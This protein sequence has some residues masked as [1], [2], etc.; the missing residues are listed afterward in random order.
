MIQ[1]GL[2]KHVHD[3]R[4]YDLFKTK[5]LGGVIPSFPK[6]LNLDDGQW[7]VDQ[8]VGFP[9]F[10]PFSPPQPYGCTNVTTCDLLR[11]EDGKLYNPQD[12]ENYTHANAKGGI[13]LRTAAEAGITLY[14]KDHPNY[15][16]VK[17][18]N[19]QGGYADWFDAVRLAI[20]VGFNEK[21]KVSI[22]TAW[23]SGFESVGSDGLISDF[24][25][26]T[27]ITGGHDW[28]G[29]GWVER[30]ETRL[31][32]KSWQ[33]QG[34]GDKGYSYFTRK[35]F[36][37]LMSEWSA[38]AFVY[39]KLTDGEQPIVISSTTKQWLVSFFLQLFKSLGFV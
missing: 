18:D 5:R 36:N 13:D 7:T 15:F 26:T 34:Y 21:R 11:T 38:S 31:I 19:K 22:G 29:V 20:L 3:K 14:K 35:Q 1:N 28:A 33:G 32:C 30:D 2:K 27:Q 16:W 37:K 10:V 25:L 12:L 6:E 23:H 39:D 24:A 8:N 4:D 9:M 17:P